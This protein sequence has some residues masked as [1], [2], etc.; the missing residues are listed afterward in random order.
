MRWVNSNST[1][2]GR[3]YL[4]KVSYTNETTAPI[5][6]SQPPGQSQVPGLDVMFT[7]GAAGTPPLNY[8]WQFNE[9]NIL[10]ETN[11]SLIVSN[12]QATNL[13]LYRVVVTNAAG[14]MVS[15]NA[16]LEFGQASAWGKTEVPSWA[17]GTVSLISAPSAAGSQP[18][19]RSFARQWLLVPAGPVH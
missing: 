15:S 5:I 10:G 18:R 17:T 9:T 1:G 7:V 6:L 13:G 8:Q 19:R 11:S 12:I 14:S 16:P 3:G 4:D 2:G